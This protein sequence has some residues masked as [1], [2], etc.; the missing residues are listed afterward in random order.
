[1]TAGEEMPRRSVLITGAGGLIGRRL[2]RALA[3]DRDGIGATAAVDVREVPMSERLPGVDYRVLD[4]CA[5]ELADALAELEVDT[6]VHLAAIVTPPPGC[7]REVQRRVDVEGTENVLG[8]CLRAGVRKLI[9]TSSGAAYGY[10]A[11]NPASLTEDAPLRGNPE[12]AYSDHKRIVEEMLERYRREHPELAQLVLRLGTVLGDSVKN[13]ITALFDGPFVLGVRG[14]TSPFTFVWDSDVVACLELG[15]RGGAAG[16]YNLGGEGVMT[17]REIAAALGKPYVAVPPRLIEVGIGALQRLGKTPYGPEQVDFLRYR[18][19]LSSAK[20]DR[21]L[22]FRP[23]MSTRAAFERYV[24]A[25]S[26]ARVR[27]PCDGVDRRR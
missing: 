9:V 26:P 6:V 13:Q 8:A 14:A 4:V 16:I 1:M 18:P 5:P 11:D 25:S 22:G 21:E 20:L 12:F 10:H 2:T 15:I 19:V 27:R 24:R 17:L 7:T 23:K 3:E